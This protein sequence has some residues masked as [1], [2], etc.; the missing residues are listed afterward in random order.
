M[1]FH[2]MW[3]NEGDTRNLQMRK[4]LITVMSLIEC[5]LI[6]YSISGI[7]TAIIYSDIFISCVKLKL[8]FVHYSSFPSW[9]SFQH[10]L[11]VVSWAFPFAIPSL[12]YHSRK[13]CFYDIWKIGNNFH[14]S[15][16]ERL[17]QIVAAKFYVNELEINH[18]LNFTQVQRRKT[19]WD[20]FSIYA[21]I[22]DFVDSTDS[23]RLTLYLDLLPSFGWSSTYFFR[24]LIR[25]Y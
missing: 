19:F 21:I 6:S 10:I 20:Y 13:K 11:Q 12:L 16:Q 23:D 9:G 17:L 5:V 4:L 2:F 15:P 18:S 25:K 7:T 1:V 22:L 8:N 3:K 24:P 14:F